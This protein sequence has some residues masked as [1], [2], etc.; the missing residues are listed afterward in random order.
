[1][2]RSPNYVVREI[3]CT[4]CSLEC[5]NRDASFTTP[6]AVFV[7]SVSTCVHSVSTFMQLDSPFAANVSCATRVETSWNK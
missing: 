4:E 5:V 6:D 7:H 1:V 3:I 2:E